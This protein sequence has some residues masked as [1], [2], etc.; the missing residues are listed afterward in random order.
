M[1]NL[2]EI[3]N[4]DEVS[5]Y[6]EEEIVEPV[7]VEEID[8]KKDISLVGV[9]QYDVEA[10]SKALGIP[11]EHVYDNF[12][13]GASNHRN[14]EAR[15]IE[16][17]GYQGSSSEASVFNMVNPATDDKFE[18]R[19]LHDKNVFFGV[20]AARGAGRNF[21]E[22]KYKKKM[23]EIAGFIV[24][25]TQEFPRISLYCI[26]ERLANLLGE[27]SKGF[28]GRER[29]FRAYHAVFWGTEQV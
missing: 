3:F 21:N 10:L 5:E 18:F 14:I 16:E 9:I 15:V 17:L 1:K 28:V 29:F 7:V 11:E 19:L 13:S 2:S 12:T 27:N 8:L 24:A 25:D 23:S 22:D 26:S 20:S 4:L 6:T